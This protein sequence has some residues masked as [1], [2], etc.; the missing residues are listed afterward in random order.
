[1]Y[2]YVHVYVHMYVCV[3]VNTP[4]H[5]S[6]SLPLKKTTH[7]TVKQVERTNFQVLQIICIF[8]AYSIEFIAREHINF[9]F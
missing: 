4:T 6:K 5:V 2:M 8:L 1:M 7:S 3:F 9:K